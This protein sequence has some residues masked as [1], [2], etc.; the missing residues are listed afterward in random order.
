MQRKQPF[1]NKKKKEQLQKKRFNKQT[2]H[3]TLQLPRPPM[4]FTPDTLSEK[5][6]VSDDPDNGDSN[7]LFPAEGSQLSLDQLL[8]KNGFTTEPPDVD[9]ELKF[10]AAK[11]KPYSLTKFHSQPG[12]QQSSNT[13]FQL[14]FVKESEQEI[15]ARKELAALPVK[16][17][18]VLEMELSVLDIYPTGTVLDIPKRP[19]WSYNDTRV[20]IETSEEKMFE[21]YLEEI[22]SKF[23][24]ENLSYF[25]HNL[26]SWRQLWR[27]LDISQVFQICIPAFPCVLFYFYYPWLLGY[28]ANYRRETSRLTFLASSLLTRGQRFEEI[29]GPGAQQVG[30]GTSQCSHSLEAL[31]HTEV[32][33]HACY[34]LLSLSRR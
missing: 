5:D 33:R 14:H 3:H 24:N 4:V 11:L 26:E 12:Q 6:P 29:H 15:A 31:L 21:S 23:P 19:S 10:A 9:T 1:S 30:P 18:S 34:L 7:G 17:V 28:N 2:K 8:A 27:V 32:S 20:I 13:R 22:Y 25:E 16:F